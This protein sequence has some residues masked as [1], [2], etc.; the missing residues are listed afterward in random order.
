MRVERFLSDNSDERA[1]KTALV[2][3]ERRLSYGELD[4]MSSALAG[5]LADHG[6]R[7]GDRVLVF[8][9]NSWE[10][11]VSIFG[12]LKAGAT[13][14]PINP[15]TKTGKLA[16]IIEDC[17]PAA[18]LTLGRLMPVVREAL[19]GYGGRPVAVLSTEGRDSVP[20]GAHCFSASLEGSPGSVD[21]GGTDSDLAMLIYTS[22]STG[23]PK[24]VMMTHRNIEAASRSIITYLQ[25][26]ADDIV[27]NVLPL[28][29]D[30]GLYQ[31]LMSVR[32]G[33]T[34]VLQK[35]FAF[36]S[37]IFEV[38]RREH[39]TGFPLVPTMAAMILRMQDLTPGFL[40]DLRYLT[41]TAA[42]LPPEH[43]ARLR[44]LFPG[45]RLY[46]MYGLTECKRCTWLPPEELDRRPG[47]VGIAIP[48]T[49]AFV[50]DEQGRRV[51]PGVAGE[52]VIRGPHV[53]QGYWR[54]S[55]ATAAVLR[56]GADPSQIQLHTGDLF[57]ADAEEF[58]YFVGRKDDIIK[59]RG[60][61]VAPKEVEAVLH[62]MPG[63]AEAVVAGVPDP[64]LG[65]AVTAM[66]VASD[67]GLSERQILGH[68]AR[69]LEDFMVPR[70]IFLTETLPR[71][72]TGKISRRLAAAAM[73][74][75]E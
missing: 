13:F 56:T 28:A 39:V 20:D 1:G 73:E 61:K 36:P 51:A 50:V 23:Q 43:I 3:A 68:C 59:T 41:N 55:E 17:E 25:G 31:L 67:P 14:S 66:V 60:E 22:G 32:L 10:T 29:F 38:M 26:S 33:A 15:S 74:S 24:G 9:D 16:Y 40:P 53:M 12:A 58:L 27:L 7:R 75:V 19:A 2:T 54:N 71:T 21:H 37:A 69:H 63:I 44:A 30:Y 48:G 4:R 47:S 8:M 49:E 70:R 45:A 72:D 64:L 65:Q 18:I 5:A 42:A 52:L 11:A 46:S 35:S 34:L 6:V 57:H 62:A